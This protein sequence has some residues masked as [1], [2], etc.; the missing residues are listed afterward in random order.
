MGSGTELELG[1]G[2]ELDGRLDCTLHAAD[3]KVQGASCGSR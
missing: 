1:L 2:P 3:C